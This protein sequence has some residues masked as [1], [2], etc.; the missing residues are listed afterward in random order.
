MVVFSIFG[1]YLICLFIQARFKGFCPK[2]P[3]L[4]AVS[5][6]IQKINKKL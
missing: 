1:D 4:N 2:K 6:K 5:R 3:A